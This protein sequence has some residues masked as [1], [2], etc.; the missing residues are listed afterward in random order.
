MWDDG[1]L[2][3]ETFDIEEQPSLRF[4]KDGMVYWVKW[5]NDRFWT[6]EDVLDFVNNL[7]SHRSNYLRNRVK[8]GPGLYYEYV[9]SYLAENYFDEI[10]PQVLT[11][12]KILRE[13]GFD[14]DFKELNKDFGKKNVGR[15]GQMRTV[16][17]V[18]WLP[19]FL[20]VWFG[21][22]SF[23][24]VYFAVQYCCCAKKNKTQDLKKKQE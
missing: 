4:I 23:V 9:A 10:I 6:A 21:S 2:L 17:D 22:F 8:A 12:R 24:F 15:K 13:Y 5:Q 20:F 19:V 14:Y 7:P 1:E 11:A 18:L 3:K 16:M